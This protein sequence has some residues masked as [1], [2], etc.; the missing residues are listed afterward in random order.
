MSI[1]KPENNLSE[2]QKGVTLLI[3][4]IVI[5]IAMLSVAISGFLELRDGLRSS[6]NEVKSVQAYYSAEGAL[7]DVLVRLRESMNYNT[8]YNQQIGGAST[9]FAVSEDV[10][11]SRTIIG[12]ADMDGRFRKVVITYEMVASADASFHY[13]AQAG[14][15]GFII[16]NGS[17]VYGN[18]YSNGNVVMTSN[19]SI[20]ETVKIA[21]NSNKLEKGNVGG[22]VYV[23]NCID[24][25]ITGILYAN[26]N[27]GCTAAAIVTPLAS[28]IATATLPV[29]DAQI[30]KWKSDAE[31]GGVH[32]GNV[33]FDDGTHTLGPLKIAGNLT[34]S[35]DA[36][37]NMEG[38][39]WV[40]GDVLIEQSAQLKLDS[41]YGTDSG[42]FISDGQMD[43]QNTAKATGSGAAG[44][45]LML[46]ST[47]DGLEAI[48][49]E[50]SFRADILFTNRGEI[51]IQNSSNLREVT[52][53]SIH[54]ENNAEIHYESGLAD[55]SFTGGP[56][57]SWVITSWREEE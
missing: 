13:G 9:T 18:V 11:G 27:S 16:R 39:L 48:N 51:L 44:S 25:K 36:V 55:V 47:Y 29:T 53:Y 24:A 19:S 46:I 23:G 54:L 2:D 15:G 12:I 49:I 31:S 40:T 1:F 52:G 34:L 3:I 38:T 33:Y 41:A 22:D 56:G 20:T 6:A 14:D 45:Y 50:Q 21:R 5:L 32:T 8:I 57:G 28:E 37:L 30:A 43:L 26:S 17:I 10:G 42:I 4:V 7:E 35:V